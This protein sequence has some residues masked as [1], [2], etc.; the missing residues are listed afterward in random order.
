LYSNNRLYNTINQETVATDWSRMESPTS[1]YTFRDSNLQ[2]NI[3]FIEEQKREKYIMFIRKINMQF[4]D[5]VL[6]KYIWREKK[7][8]RRV[9]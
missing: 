7:K 8:D 4:S 9:I 2:E 5:D 6:I 1:P 3:N